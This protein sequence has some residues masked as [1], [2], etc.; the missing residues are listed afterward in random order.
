MIAFQ[1]KALARNRLDNPLAFQLSVSLGN[2]VAI[3]A[4]F[5]GEWT[6]GGQRLAFTQ[7]ARRRGIAYLVGQLEINRFTG[8]K[9]NLENHIPS[10]SLLYNTMTV[11][12]QFVKEFFM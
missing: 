12:A 4:Q 9:I 7:P 8:L 11:A 5:L 1:K 6:K 3:N 2:S 10:L